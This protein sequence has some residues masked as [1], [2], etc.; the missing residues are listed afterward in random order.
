MTRIQRGRAWKAYLHL[1]RLH[2][3]EGLCE[4]AGDLLVDVGGV[5]GVGGGALGG[6][7]PQGGLDDFRGHH[8]E[9]VVQDLG[10]HLE[11]RLVERV[12]TEKTR[13]HR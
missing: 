4:Q 12:C 1:S 6:H 9:Q 2:V 10:L 13:F 3:G 8:Q 5:V 11:P 7:V